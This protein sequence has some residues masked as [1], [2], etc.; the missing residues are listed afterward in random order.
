MKLDQ[1]DPSGF[2]R[3]APRWRE[4]VWLLVSEMLF[5]T[6][7]PGSAWRVALLRLFG[8]QIGRGVLIKPHVHIKFPWR[9]RIGQHCWIGERVWIDN[10]ADVNIGDHVCISQGAYLCTGS[11]DWTSE[12]FDLIVKPIKLD[13]NCWVGAKSVVAPGCQV[14][15]GAVLTI[16]SVASGYLE[17]W[18]VYSGSPAQPTRLRSSA[19]SDDAI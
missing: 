4:A 13:R 3:G 17:S 10:L 15:E 2:D 1:F 9:L 5:S 14:S 18:T 16:G 19:K 7:L 12:S 11:H 8:A 6:F